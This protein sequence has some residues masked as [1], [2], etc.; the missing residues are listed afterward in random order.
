MFANTT[1]ACISIIIS[2]LVSAR[3]SDS[4]KASRSECSW[5]VNVGFSSNSRYRDGFG[6]EIVDGMNVGGAE[7]EI[8]SVGDI[9]NAAAV[10]VRLFTADCMKI[11]ADEAPDVADGPALDSP[12]DD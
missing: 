4:N 2:F 7:V 9:R 11:G 8:I 12:A 1:P 5:A 10:A 3:T 6:G